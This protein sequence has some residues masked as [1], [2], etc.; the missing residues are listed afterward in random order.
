[1]VELGIVVIIGLLMME[2]ELLLDVEIPQFP[3]RSLEAS[4]V[5]LEYAVV[6]AH[7]PAK[8]FWIHNYN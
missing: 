8:D 7:S 1:M 5:G 6:E 3:D 2:L 4:A